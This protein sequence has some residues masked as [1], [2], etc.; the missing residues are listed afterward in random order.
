MNMATL[1]VT[2]AAGGTV[3][4]GMPY[5]SAVRTQLGLR[6]KADSNQC[7]TIEVVSQK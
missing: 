2:G 5:A 6:R 1:Y 4:P 7:A 3:A